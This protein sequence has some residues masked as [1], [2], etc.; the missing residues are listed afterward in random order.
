MTDINMNNLAVVEGFPTYRINAEGHVY[1]AITGDRIEPISNTH[2]KLDGCVRS[3]DILLAETYIGKGNYDVVNGRT[4][5]NSSRQ[6]RLTYLVESLECIEDGVFI[7]NDSIEFHTIPLK[8]N[9][10]LISTEG[11]IY[12]N[13]KKDFVHRSWKNGRVMAILYTEP[14]SVAA[15]VY[16]TFIDEIPDG[17]HI[18]FID[19]NMYNIH[20]DNLAVQTIAEIRRAAKN[21]RG[22]AHNI[23]TMRQVC[24]IIAARESND[25]NTGGNDKIAELLGLPYETRADK[26]RIA[27]IVDKLKNRTGYYDDLKKEFG[28]TKSNA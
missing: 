17:M 10:Y 27:S 3:I 22:N 12:D 19:G 25:Y 4:T 18:K 16:R 1:D 8:D 14:V 24:E 20:P 21:Q 13:L 2:I 9:R 23:N 5:I 15:C 26:H 7:M 28:F 11:V 6:Q